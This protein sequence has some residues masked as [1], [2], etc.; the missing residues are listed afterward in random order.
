MSV[1]SPTMREG[2]QGWEGA[3]PDRFDLIARRYADR[4]A[5]CDLERQL[6]YAEL[7]ADADRIA[8]AVAAMEAPDGP[9]AL[10]APLDAR[11]VAGFHGALAA[12]RIVVPIDPEHPAE[13]NRRIAGHCGV[14]AA[15]APSAL[16][17]PARALLSG[18]LPLLELDRLSPAPGPA[19]KRPSADD[20][21][22]VIYTS[23]STGQPKGVVHSHC[24][25]L[26]ATEVLSRICELGPE[27]RTGLFFAGTMTTIALIEAATLTGAALHIL[28]A[29]RLGAERLVEEIRARELTVL[30]IVPTLLRRVAETVGTGR[31]LDHVRVVRL[32]GERCEWGDVELIRAAFGSHVQIKLGIASTEV[33]IS[34]AH[35]TIED[36]LASEGGRLPVGRA[37]PSLGLTLCDDDGAPVPE[38]EIGEAVVSSPHVALGYW[39]EPELSA[40]A[41]RPAPCEPRARTFATADMCRRRPDGLIEFV[42]RKDELVKLRGHRIEP[43]EVES[44][45]RSCSGVAD[46]ALVVRSTPEGRARA[47]VAYVERRPAEEGLLP[48]H[49][50]SMTSRK[51]PAYM[52]PSVFYVE[53]LPRLPNFKIDRQALQRLDATRASDPS[54]RQGDP[55]LDL[56]ACAFEAVIGCSGATGEDDL[57]SLG[58]DSLQA[59]EVLLELQRR[60]GRKVPMRTFSKARNLAELAAALD[61]AKASP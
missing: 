61:G 60:L 32:M 6:T 52:V 58:G 49:I 17:D 33:P 11:L 8:R 46:A 48:R 34:Y 36:R 43:A 55:M 1:V 45:I 57:L 19:P 5:V 53:P 16:A 42:G 30:H 54:A 9:L 51:L 10:V 27:D 59:V 24:G 23:G 50:F 40:A 26:A 56:V 12:G 37:T 39:R 20:P 38:G 13:R 15:L 29:Q 18:A 44:A 28:P 21:A 3:L 41:F 2:S 35:W 22:F 7:A 4:V 31:R 25:A 14:T 47:L